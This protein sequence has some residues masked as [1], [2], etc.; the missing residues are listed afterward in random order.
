MPHVKS[1][2]HNTIVCQESLRGT[3]GFLKVGQKKWVGGVLGRDERASLFW[4]LW[5]IV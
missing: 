5:V 1:N 2:Q 4:L 3:Q